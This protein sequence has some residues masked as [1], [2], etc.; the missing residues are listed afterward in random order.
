MTRRQDNGILYPP[1]PVRDRLHRALFGFIGRLGPAVQERLL[2]GFFE[3]IYLRR[4]PWH[5]EDTPY[6]RQKCDAAL[7]VIPRQD[8]AR[9]L[10]VGCGEGLF[11]ELLL[12]GR[13]IGELIGLDI[14]AR[15]VQRAGTRCARFSNARFRSENA[16]TAPLAGTFDLIIACEVLYY[17]G[18]ALAPLAERL[19][20][21]LA[22]TG[23]M[24]LVHPWPQ[25]VALHRSFVQSGGYVVLS[26]SVVRGSCPRP[27]CV[28]VLAAY[29]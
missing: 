26:E 24:V 9:V 14:S 6:Q 10:E 16:L 12:E 21:H 13:N 3:R 8:Y 18:A 20:Q 15:A 28:Y 23:R 27:F 22:P 19:A 17:L 11:S 29:G 25:A 2:R 4:N 7:A 1:N 5:Y